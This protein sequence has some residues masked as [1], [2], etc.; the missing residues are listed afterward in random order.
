MTV[1]VITTKDDSE[2]LNILVS[3]IPQLDGDEISHKKALYLSYR[4]SN[5]TVHESCALVPCSM[6]Q[7]KRW[8]DAD[9]NFRKLDGEGLTELRKKMGMEFLDMQFTRNFRMVMERD[10]RILYK[11]A[12][13]GIGGLTRSE[14]T[15]A[16]KIRQHYT[17]QSLA[18]V[19]QLLAGGNSDAPFDFTKFVMEIQRER[20]TIERR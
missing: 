8:R 20:I 11:E 19:K 7:V 2:T 3:G 9:E 13:E 14:I 10:F 6:K 4:I 5:F 18:L 12:T 1:D 16:E 15:Y 17:P